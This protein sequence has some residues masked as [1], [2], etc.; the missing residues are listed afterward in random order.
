MKPTNAIQ[1][2]AT[3]QQENAFVKV[4]EQLNKDMYMAGLDIEFPTDISP[5]SLVNN[6]QL[7]VETLLLKQYDNYLTLMYRVDVQEAELLKLNGLF[8]DDLIKE[9]TFLILKREWQKVYF[10]SKF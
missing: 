4:V 10:R 3:V 6:L 5:V 9:I 8:A 1:L 2:L 7:H